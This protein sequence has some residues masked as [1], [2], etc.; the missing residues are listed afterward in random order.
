MWLECIGVVSGC[1]CKEVDN[2]INILIIIIAFSYSTCISSF[3]TAAS[4]LLCS[5]LKCFLFFNIIIIVPV[6]R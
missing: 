4:L 1:C 5:F 2:I 6:S 3:F